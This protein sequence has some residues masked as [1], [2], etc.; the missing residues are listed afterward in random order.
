MCVCVTLLFW[1]DDK[2]FMFNCKHEM[3]CHDLLVLVGGAW[4]QVSELEKKWTGSDII[5]FLS[6]LS[7][8]TDVRPVSWEELTQSIKPMVHQPQ[9]QGWHHTNQYQNQWSIVHDA[10]AQHLKFPSCSNLTLL[11]WLF[12]YTQPQLWGGRVLEGVVYTR[13]ESGAKEE[14]SLSQKNQNL[15]DIFWTF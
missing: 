7:D 1:L 14:V 6:C 13:Q 4:V 8:G 11:L 9:E 15:C 12:I 10:P 5:S 2:L 3:W